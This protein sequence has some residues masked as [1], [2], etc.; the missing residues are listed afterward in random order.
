MGITVNEYDQLSAKFALTSD[1]TRALPEGQRLIALILIKRFELADTSIKNMIL[2]NATKP[3]FNNFIK[4]VRPRLEQALVDLPD[5]AE[6]LKSTHAPIYHSVI[7]NKVYDSLDDFLIVVQFAIHQAARKDLILTNKARELNATWLS[8]YLVKPVTSKRKTGQQN[9]LQMLNVLMYDMDKFNQIDAYQVIYI[10][11]VINLYVHNASY[12]PMVGYGK[13]QQREIDHPLLYARSQGKHAHGLFFKQLTA[14]DAR[15]Q[16]LQP[17]NEVVFKILKSVSTSG[18]T[19]NLEKYNEHGY[20]KP[21]YETATLDYF[22]LQFAHSGLRSNSY[23]VTIKAV[24][25]YLDQHTPADLI[26]EISSNFSILKPT[27]NQILKLSPIILNNKIEYVHN[28]AR[29][30]SAQISIRPYYSNLYLALTH[31]R[32]DNAKKIHDLSAQSALKNIKVSC[33]LATNCLDIQFYPDKMIE[34]NANYKEGVTNVIINFFVGL[35]NHQLN[36]S[37]MYVQAQRR[38]SFAFNRITVTDTTNMCMRVSLGYEPKTFISPF[39]NA[40]SVLD[41][42]LAVFNFL[43]RGNVYLKSG[44]VVGE[45][46]RNGVENNNSGTKFLNVMRSS[47]RMLAAIQEAQQAL[48]LLRGNQNYEYTAFMNYI[49]YLVGATVNIVPPM[50]STQPAQSLDEPSKSDNIL[51]VGLLNNILKFTLEKIQESETIAKN[52]EYV[53]SYYQIIAKLIKL[54]YKASYWLHNHTSFYSSHVYAKTLLLVDDMLENMVMLDS[55]RIAVQ[56]DVIDHSVAVKNLTNVEKLY[57]A[58]S[59][60]ISPD[61]VDV[62]FADNG[63]QSLT[64]SVLCMSMQLFDQTAVDSLSTNIFAFGKCYYELF[65][66]LEKNIDLVLCETA[67]Q[68]QFILVDIREIDEFRQQQLE[69]TRARVIV[70]DCTHNPCLPDR[71]LRIVVNE[72]LVNNKWVVIVGSMLKHEQLGLDKFQAGKLIVMSPPNM[73]LNINVRDELESITNA[74]MHPV[75]AGYFQMINDI[76]RDKVIVPSPILGNVGL[77][78]S[79]PSISLLDCKEILDPLYLYNTK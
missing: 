16:C 74:A 39:I 24:A 7:A 42:I 36:E 77:F 26:K 29:H 50:L 60:G 40:L 11:S 9:F 12:A 22:S 51:V 58:S 27:Q 64:V 54:C 1:K 2:P 79:G 35:L 10:S 43:D 49:N 15:K 47:E 56:K 41:G 59:L 57:A 31:F 44:F 3:T 63:Q 20:L 52:Q 48:N 23:N 6:K 21:G 32:R 72:L 4:M 75:I 37:G 5:I 67:S 13:A 45:K 46:L 61:K 66:N 53:H 69:L 14:V 19:K 34:D 70:I 73:Q 8:D 62:F 38:Q 17:K 68:A 78:K 33:D 18:F 28:V 71:E 25:Y 30:L 55:L 76:C 65:P